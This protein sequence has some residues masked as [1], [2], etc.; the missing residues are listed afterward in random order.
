MQGRGGADLTTLCFYSTNESREPL[1][2]G[3]WPQVESIKA[4]EQCVHDS[5]PAM[6]ARIAGLNPQGWFY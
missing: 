2:L 1:K 3:L 6:M 4:Q 5:I